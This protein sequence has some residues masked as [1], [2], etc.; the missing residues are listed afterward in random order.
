MAYK[1]GNGRGAELETFW[2]IHKKTPPKPELCQALRA[3]NPFSICN[4]T[5]AGRHPRSGQGF[6]PAPITPSF[7]LALPKG[8]P[9]WNPQTGGLGGAQLFLR[10][11][12]NTARFA[13]GG[14]EFVFGKGSVCRNV[15]PHRLVLV[16]GI[17]IKTCGI[18]VIA[19][20]AQRIHSARPG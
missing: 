1:T 16:V 7:F 17:L 18:Q 8:T 12:A 3:V 9:L 14:A 13:F 4:K 10:C 11:N 15:P 5:G 19:A 6:L 2:L 20:G